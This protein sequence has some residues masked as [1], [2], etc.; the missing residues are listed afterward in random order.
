MIGFAGLSHLGVVS[1]IAT[2]SKGNQVIGYDPD[3]NLCT[4]LNAGQLPVVEPGLAELLSASL[5][6]LRFTHNPAELA[7]CGLIFLSLDLTTDQN[8]RSQLPS[9]NKLVDLVAANASSGTVLS[10]MSQVPPGFTRKLADGLK[11]RSSDTGLQVYY[12]VETLVIGQAVERAVNPERFIVGCENP[13]EELPG[14]YG[15]VLESFG[16][17]VLKM[18]YESAELAK[19]SVNMFLA[20]SVSTANTLAELCEAIGA[21][22]SEIVPA[23]QLDR[24]IG[25]HAY[26]A[27][28]LGLAG[29]NLER[30]LVTIRGLAAEF[31]TEAGVVDAWLSNSRH[32]RSWVLEILNS[33]VLSQLDDPT[34]AV[35]GL[36][37]KP[38]TSSTR[39]SPAL[40][41]VDALKPFDV[42]VYD[43]VVV[44]D[45]T[46]RP[47]VVQTQSALDACRGADAL[48]IMTP[49]REFSTIDLGQ[50]REEMGGRVII[51]PFGVIQS[52]RC[53]SLGFSYFRLGLPADMAASTID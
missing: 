45:A 49:W 35:W 16:A 39:N 10:L 27:P 33:Q 22:W 13:Q 21:D 28:G 48:T 20:S 47:S 42:R 23:L 34:I 38:D 53:A 25:P 30:D 14:L 17:P 1:S 5:P 12:Q 9:L 2:A 4:A 6:F 52:T 36:A 11:S 24:R 7:Q 40:A 46:E 3:E 41:L 29:G 50:I 31:G 44:L 15:Q 51:D 32:R 8:N 26:L 37:Y 18:G 43:P 19:A